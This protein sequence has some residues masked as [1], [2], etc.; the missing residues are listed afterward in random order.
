MKEGGWR[1]L[2]Y[3]THS[4]VLRL[5]HSS[6]QIRSRIEYLILSDSI[7]VLDLVLQFDEKKSNLIGISFNIIYW[8]FCNGLQFGAIIYTWISNNLQKLSNGT[9]CSTTTTTVLAPSENRNVV[10]FFYCNCPT[11]VVCRYAVSMVF[12]PV[13]AAFHVILCR[14]IVSSLFP[15]C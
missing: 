1:H 11:H 10:L 7:T 8:R 14:Y 6:S 9:D 4:A 15:E 13:L 3:M 2:R 5:T 12:Y